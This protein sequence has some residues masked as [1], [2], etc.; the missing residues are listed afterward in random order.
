MKRILPVL[1]AILLALL[2]SCPVE[3]PE[4]DPD[5]AS[6]PV[7]LGVMPYDSEMSYSGGFPGSSTEG[8]YYFHIDGGDD[9]LCAINTLFSLEVMLLPPPCYNYSLTLLDGVK[10]GQLAFSDK[11]S[12]AEEK[13][14]FDWKGDCVDNDSRDFVVVVASVDGSVSASPFTLIIKPI[15]VKKSK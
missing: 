4:D 5:D 14:K 13:I 9:P 2:L 12:C 1:T 3:P 7:D 15:K 6:G 11:D 8:V 10:L